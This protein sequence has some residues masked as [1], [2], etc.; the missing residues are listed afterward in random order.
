MREAHSM[1]DHLPNIYQSFRADFPSV[2]QAQDAVAQSVTAA[3]PLDDKTQRLVK[4]GIAI[5]SLAEGAVR[6]GARQALEGGASEAEV[7]QIALMAITTRG[8]PAAIAALGWVRE[9]FPPGT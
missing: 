5:G 3:G 1:T 9:V 4:L 6:S 7:E 8:F 2:A